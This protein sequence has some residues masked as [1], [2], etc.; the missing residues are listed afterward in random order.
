VIHVLLKHSGYAL[1][2]PGSANRSILRPPVTRPSFL[3]LKDKYH[4]ENNW[5]DREH[6]LPFIAAFPL[7]DQPPILLTKAQVIGNTIHAERFQIPPA[8]LPKP[9]CK[10]ASIMASATPFCFCTT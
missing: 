6:G 8:K 9:V 7:M 2:F 3:E 5:V 4:A 1:N 10:R